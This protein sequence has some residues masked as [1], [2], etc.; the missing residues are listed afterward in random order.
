MGEARRERGSFWNGDDENGTGERH[1]ADDGTA[2]DSDRAAVT[3]DYFFRDGEAH[4]DASVGPRRAA[5]ALHKGL[6]YLRVLC[7]IDALPLIGHR[8]FKSL[9]HGANADA[10][11]ARLFGKFHCIFNDLNHRPMQSVRV[12]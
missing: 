8:H 5:I 10:N 6:K 12:A 9:V 4:A 11:T 7:L 3:L 1:A 2:R